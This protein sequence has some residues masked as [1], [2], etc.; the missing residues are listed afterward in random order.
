MLWYLAVIGNPSQYPASGLISTQASDLTIMWFALSAAP[1]DNT[2]PTSNKTIANT[3]NFHGGV[4]GVF[5][6]T[7]RVTKSDGK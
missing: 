6:V 7:V 4:A 5:N 3:T 1:S 2:S